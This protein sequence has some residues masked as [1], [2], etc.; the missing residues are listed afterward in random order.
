MINPNQDWRMQQQRYERIIKSYQLNDLSD[1]YSSLQESYQ[2]VVRQLNK[3][4]DKQKQL[5]DTLAMKEVELNT[6]KQQRSDLANPIDTLVEEQ[7]SNLFIYHIETFEQLLELF[8]NSQQHTL[9]EVDTTMSD[10]VQP[11]QAKQLGQG[12]VREAEQVTLNEEPKRFN[13]NDLKSYQSAYIVPDRKET[14][15][16]SLR[17][18][19]IYLDKKKVLMKLKEKQLQRLLDEAEALHQLTK[20]K[21][22]VTNEEGTESTQ[23][24]EHPSELTSTT[25]EAIP[26]ET[27]EE[28]TTIKKDEIPTTANEEKIPAIKEE[29]APAT[30]EEKLPTVTQGELTGFQKAIAQLKKLFSPNG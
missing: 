29:A 4:M 1:A 28:L 7:L 27:K 8:V 30:N 13:F 23:K 9:K 19:Q 12:K 20:R 24:E 11:D 15:S 5:E 21:E 25:E 6:L 22:Q 16:N 26:V 10:D 2:S 18:P 3:Y 17:S 14:Q